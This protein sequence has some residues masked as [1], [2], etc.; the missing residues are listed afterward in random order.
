MG[1]GQIKFLRNFYE[2]YYI[3]DKGKTSEDFYQIFLVKIEKL[4]HYVKRRT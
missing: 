2:E 3:R 4:G 1:L